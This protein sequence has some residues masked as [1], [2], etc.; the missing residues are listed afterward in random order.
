MEVSFLSVQSSGVLP[1][2]FPHTDFAFLVSCQYTPRS[3]LYT[4]H[5]C[6][7]KKR[8]QQLLNDKNAEIFRQKHI[9]KE[10]NIDVHHYQ[11][12]KSLKKKKLEKK[13][14]IYKLK[15]TAL[16]LYIIIRQL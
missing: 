7:E 4:G 1:N 11:G 3:D 16:N 6:C 14:F 10:M 5:W 13:V 8:A 15:S 12:H 9:K 2:W